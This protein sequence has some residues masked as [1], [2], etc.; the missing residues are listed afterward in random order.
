MKLAVITPPQSFN[1]LQEAGLG[2]HMA[3]GQELVRSAEYRR[4]YYSLRLKGHYII[5]DNGAAESDTLPFKQI[6]EIANKI[7]ADEIAMPDVLRDMER[8]VIATRKAIGLV[9]KT[10]RML[11]PQGKDWAA[12]NECV[13]QLML[14]GG[15]SLGIPKLLEQYPGGRARAL[16][17]LVTKGIHKEIDVHLLGANENPLNEISVLQNQFS[18]IR[19]IDTGAPVAYAQ[20]NIDMQSS[21][22]ASLNW[23]TPASNFLVCSNIKELLGVCNDK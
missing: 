17:Y 13:K 18:W 16:D 2:Y 12:W 3:L 10:K 23:H 8:T 9:P 11:I 7:G 14:K 21:T 19:G 6:V 15:K 22:R 20:Q 5:V 1:V 4:M